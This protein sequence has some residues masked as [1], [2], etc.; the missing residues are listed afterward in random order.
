[1]Q[2]TTDEI[3]AMTL[4]ALRAAAAEDLLGDT[5]VA[6]DGFIRFRGAIWRN[7][8]D[9]NDWCRD[10]LQSGENLHPG[11]WLGVVDDAMIARPEQWQPMHRVIQMSLGPRWFAGY[12]RARDGALICYEHA[13][14]ETATLRAVLLALA[15]EAAAK[16]GA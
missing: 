9:N 15:A 11:G 1:M 4:P 6:D 2:R 12:V 7:P 10:W 14:R 5:K 13:D 8:A 16:G 3:N